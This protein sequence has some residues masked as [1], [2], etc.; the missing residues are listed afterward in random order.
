LA[1]ALEPNNA[2]SSLFSFLVDPFAARD[3]LS[4]VARSASIARSLSEQ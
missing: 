4:H 1:S 2:F 3:V